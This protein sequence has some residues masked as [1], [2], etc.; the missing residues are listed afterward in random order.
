MIEK[1]K[2][3]TSYASKRIK[4]VA[5]E[6]GI[7]FRIVDPTDCEVIASRDSVGSIYIKQKKIKT[8]PDCVLA[9]VGS[10]STYFTATV[11]RHLE[12][13]GVYTLNNSDSIRI[14]RD[15]LATIQMLASN[16][17]PIP[18][19]IL[20]KLPLNIDLIKNEIGFPLLIK[21][22]TASLGKGIVLCKKQRELED[23]ADV[24]DENQD[25]IIQQFIKESSGQ[26]I[27][28]LVVGGK[29]LDAILRKGKRGSFKANHAQGGT[30]QPIELTPE[31]EWL[32]IESANL[33]GLEI[34]GVDLLFEGGSY[35]VCEVNS[36]PGFE[37][38][39]QV[40]GIDVPKAIFDYIRVRIGK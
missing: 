11:L 28:V 30:V 10:A 6:T 38:F 12:K 4:E 27:R 25:F 23:I 33:L 19:T 9:R 13:L 39:E 32:A 40:T 8:L 16:N 34:A 35:C 1:K 21:K 20:A 18:K 3:I 26:D 17:I 24:L 31:M 15:K 22:V 14:A 37:G 7:R 29:P 5:K 36:V 2:W